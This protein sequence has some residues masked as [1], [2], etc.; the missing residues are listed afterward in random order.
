MERRGTAAERRK[1]EREEAGSSLVALADPESMECG[2]CSHLFR[3]RETPRCRMS[4]RMWAECPACSCLS[5][6][7]IEHLGAGEAAQPPGGGESS[8][9]G[10]SPSSSFA[11]QL[12]AP[13]EGNEEEQEPAE[14]QEPA[15]EEDE[16]EDWSSDE[17]EAGSGEDEFEFEE[18]GAGADI[19]A[20]LPTRQLR[21]PPARTRR[22]A[23]KA[24]EQARQCV[25]CQCPCEDGETLKRLPCLHEFHCGCID[26]WLQESAAC[27]LCNCDARIGHLVSNASAEAQW[28]GMQTGL[29]ASILLRQ[30]A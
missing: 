11:E 13:G 15:E 27:P 21:L 18:K 20:A 2:S 9:I 17:S 25:I 16:E 14:W 30:G 1:R 6:V 7:P 26:R 8:G 23:R 22:G 4:G 10:G 28:A 19:I 5:V 24:A 3:W 12:E 29:F